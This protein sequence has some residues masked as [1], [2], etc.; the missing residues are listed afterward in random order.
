MADR[1][2]VVDTNIFIDHFRKNNKAETTLAKLSQTYRLA[3]TSITVY[4][5]FLGAVTPAHKADLE[6][7]LLGVT[8]YSLDEGAAQIAAQEK[9]RLL[10]EIEIR[11]TLIAGI[12]LQNQLPLATLNPKH[13]EHF[14]DIELVKLMSE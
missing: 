11:D 9:L 7:L 2:I 8:V 3:T 14:R 1:T 4:E 13:F 6:K 5:L 12:V 10:K